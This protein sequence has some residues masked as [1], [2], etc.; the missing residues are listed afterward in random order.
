MSKEIVINSEKEQ[1]QI[2]IVEN[3]ELVELFIENPE[4]ARTLGDIYLGRVRRIMPSIQAAFVDIGQKQDAFLHFSDLADNLPEMLEFLEQDEP[5]VGAI[6]P[7]DDGPKPIARRRRPKKGSKPVVVEASDEEDGPTVRQLRSL[8]TKERARRRSMQRR[9]QKRPDS[10]PRKKSQPRRKVENL[11]RYLKRDQHLLVKIVKEPISNKGSRLFIENP[12]HARTLGDIYLGRV[13]RIMPSI[14]AAFVDIGQKQDAFLHFSDL[15]DNLPEMLEF[16]EQDEP[17]VGAIKPHDD[18]P[19]PIARRRRPKKGSKPVVVEAS[20]EED[21]PTVRQLRSLDTKERARRR[22]MQRRLQKRPDSEPRKKSQPRRK[23]ENLERYLK[24]DQ[25][26]LVKIVKEPISNKGSRVS[27]DISLAGR[28]LVLVPLADYVAVSK[29]IGSY[30]ERRRLR[31]L[32]RMLVPDGFGVIVRTV[33]EGRNAKALDTDLRLLL[34]KWRNLEQRLAEHPKPPALVHEDVNMVSSIIRDLF[35]DDYDRIIVD[36]PRLFR[37]IKSYIQAV[38]PQMVPAV[39]L[40]K[41]KQ[42]IFEAT[43]IMKTVE[44]AFE[45]RVDLPTGGYLFIERTEAMHVVDVNSGRSGKGMTQEENSL[46][47]NLEAARILARQIRLRDLG[48]IIVVDFI[49]LKHD[50]NKKKV[51]DE[52]KREFRKDRAVTKLLP[53]SD[54]GLVQITRQRLRPSITSTFSGPNGSSSTNGRGKSKNGSDNN[55]KESAP[56]PKT[57]QQPEPRAPEP[58]P[59]SSTA[60]SS[61]LNEDESFTKVAEVEQPDAVDQPVRFQVAGTMLREIDGDPELLIEEIEDWLGDFRSLGRR[62]PVNLV[63]HPYVSAY[64]LR[65]IPALPT[66]WFMRHFVRVRIVPDASVT[67]F[68]FLMIDP[69]T[70]ND[71]TASV[72]NACRDNEKNNENGQPAAAQEKA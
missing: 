61:A 26:L 36:D 70:G 72:R 25:H 4:H 51:Y 17:V 52:L 33:A 49:D 5:V 6:K 62:G 9:L 34:E 21:G 66:R 53:M 63:V 41:G 30:K 20:D 47:V 22:S 44:Q 23:V 38:A 59:V 11:E 24:R 71:L 18:G 42:P 35:S 19:K 15:A 43:G 13:R 57:K 1:T 48:G 56:T 16:L 39:Q 8:D 14:Q 64:L 46:R 40:H 58:E 2:A 69:R 32:A 10:E 68:R 27:T 3:N 12:E 37:N 55:Q 65:K 28:F 60:P 54:F 45:H 31:A 7:H 29:K 67:P 50:K